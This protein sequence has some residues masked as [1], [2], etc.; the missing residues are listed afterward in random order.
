M[1]N[2]KLELSNEAMDDLFV[3]M[4]NDRLQGALYSSAPG[5]DIHPED[6]ARNIHTAASIVEL[7]RG[8]RSDKEFG[9]WYSQVYLPMLYGYKKN[10]GCRDNEE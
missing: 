7:M 8:E 1:S 4:L 2:V 3:D 6:Y 10:Y 9:W 5:M